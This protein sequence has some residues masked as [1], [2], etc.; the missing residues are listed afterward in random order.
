MFDLFIDTY[1]FVGGVANGGQGGRFP[2]R[3]LKIEKG[4]KI[5]GRERMRREKRERKEGREGKKEKAKKRKKGKGKK[6]ERREKRKGKRR[7]K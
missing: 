2:P 5:S 3:T 4:R 7:E 1:F 6:K